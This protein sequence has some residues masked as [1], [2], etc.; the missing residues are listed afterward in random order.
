[1]IGAIATAEVIELFF[2]QVIFRAKYHQKLF[3]YKCTL[4]QLSTKN[5]IEFL[6]SC[7]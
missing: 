1:M 2:S 7:K 6:T 5:C 4:F 3:A